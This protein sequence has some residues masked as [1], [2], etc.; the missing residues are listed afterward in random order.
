MAT[1]NRESIY[2]LKS[3]LRCNFV[4]EYCG[5][6]VNVLD[7]TEFYFCELNEN[8]FLM[9]LISVRQ[10]NPTLYFLTLLRY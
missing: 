3:S 5:D 9:I 6:D 1:C 8:I 2:A 10:P 7:M 4:K